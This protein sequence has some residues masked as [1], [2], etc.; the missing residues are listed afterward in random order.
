[1]TESLVDPL[2]AEAR[3]VRRLSGLSGARVYMMTRDDRTWF[4]RKGAA[5]VEHNDRL[6]RQARKQAA[7]AAMP[8]DAVR[9][10]SIL[11]EGTIDGRYYFD[12]EVVHGVDAATYL[13]ISDYASVRRFTA[14][15]CDYLRAAADRPPLVALAGGQTLFDYLYSRICEVQALTT[16]LSPEVLSGVL[17]GLDQVRSAG[18]PRMTLSHG[19]LTLENI[20]VDHE[21]R[22]WFLDLLDSPFESYRQD[23]AKLHQDLDGGWYLRR[24]E[25]IARCVG[26]YVGRQV[27]QT[28]VRLDPSYAVLHP[29]LMAATFI[30]IIPYVADAESR[31]FVLER[32]AHYTA[33]IRR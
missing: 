22:L 4:V 7:L 33:L 2:I 23:V 8:V 16:A 17:V 29:V 6:R 32:V 10:P 15:L 12:M 25:A 3:A 27:F 11:D 31:R 1:V 28:A 14:Q 24:Q 5:T 18:D 19:D 30:R 21:G 20:V 9:T 13:R 26:D